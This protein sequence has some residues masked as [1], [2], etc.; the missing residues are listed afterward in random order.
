MKP[1]EGTVL[2][3][4]L[5]LWRDLSKRLGLDYTGQ[6]RTLDRASIATEEAH[7]GRPQ[8]PPGEAYTPKQLL[9]Y[10]I[11]LFFYMLHAINSY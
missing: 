8:S 1:C 7:G 10:K 11:L 2:R 9:W 5:F 4:A 3:R 6:A